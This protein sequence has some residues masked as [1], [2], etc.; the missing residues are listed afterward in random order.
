VP[1]REFTMGQ[2]TIIKGTEVSFYI[3]PTG[4]EVVPD[5]QTHHFV[6]EAATLERLEYCI[7]LDENGEKRYVQGPAVVFPEPTETFVED[8][9]G[10]S[11]QR[12]FKA[13][14]LNPQSGLYVKVIANYSEGGKQFRVGQEL[15]ITGSEDAIYF[16]RPEHSIIK[17]GDQQKHHAIA[18][19][20]G[21]G[22]YVLDRTNGKVELVRGPKMFLPDPRTQVV[23]RRILDRDTVAV[24]FPDNREALDVNEEFRLQQQSLAPG[25]FLS[26]GEARSQSRIQAFNLATK[27]AYAGDTITRGTSFSE[28][29]SIVLD[30]KYQG[31]VSINVWPGYAVLVTKKSGERRVVSG[32]EN[33]LLEYDE[34]LMVLELSTGRPKTDDRLLRT[35]YLRT[36]NN[37]VSDKVE[38][39]T[40][41]LVPVA[42]ELSYRV[43]FVGAGE[44][45][46][47]WFD[48]ENYVKVLT[49][50]CRSRLRN[51]AKHY[52]IDEFY[53]NT[54]DIVRD[55]LLGVVPENG[56]RP[57]LLFNENGMRLYDIEVLNVDILDRDIN[58]LMS[59][60]M[61]RTLTGAIE[62]L[63]AEEQTKRDVRLQE[64]D[65]QGIDER[66]KTEKRQSQAA[67]AGLRRTLEQQLAK[68]G[69]DH[70]ITVEEHRIHALTREDNRAGE[71]QKLEFQVKRDEA[72]LSR[73]R[74]EVEVFVT[75]MG[76]INGGVIEALQAFGDKNFARAIVEA[77]GPAALAAGITTADLLEQ[78][79]KNTPFEDLFGALAV[80]PNR[81]GS[82]NES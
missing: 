1:A 7:L 56:E 68:V 15:F 10:E 38:V 16:P 25:E 51:A 22:R 13:I 50:H 11:G 36:V 70:H 59:R 35:A 24:L 43:N 20:A 60:S 52:G 4:V 45:R 32:P 71:E 57:G 78:V 76:A 54:I 5:P 8:N 30:T 34:S 14:E 64:L 65:R 66:E 2:L 18:I 3:P 33:I 26:S 41:D 73:L 37:Q 69:N 72:E 40:R 82:G 48:I 19:P 42:I 63:E 61:S 81:L 28:P 53:R 12:K 39:E 23:V 27:E 31:A 21:E 62:L 46:S 55:T 9:S 79:F 74:A 67:L 44:E 58:E 49:D 75:R 29:R 77:I 17:Y 80:R 47:K 6:R